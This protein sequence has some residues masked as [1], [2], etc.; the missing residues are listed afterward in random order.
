MPS[1]LAAS[2]SFDQLARILTRPTVG[3]HIVSRDDVTDR[4]V[5][6][7]FEANSTQVVVDVAVPNGTVGAG[8]NVWFGGRPLE[9][10]FDSSQ[11]YY[12]VDYQLGAGSYYDK[13]QVIELLTDSSSRFVDASRDDS[14]DWRYR[15]SSL[16]SLYPEGVRRIIATALTEDADLLDGASQVTT[17]ATRDR[18]SATTASP[19]GRWRRACGGPRRAPRSAG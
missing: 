10:S 13:T 2:Q 5:L 15:Q 17:E 12:S 19:L 3:P 4:D 9:N 14:Y 1:A 11:G 18:S 8:S 6:R 7:F 16:A